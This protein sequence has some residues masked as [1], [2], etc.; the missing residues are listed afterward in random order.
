MQ[1]AYPGNLMSEKEFLDRL[2]KAGLPLTKTFK[3]FDPMKLV[4][5]PFKSQPKAKPGKAFLQGKV[6]ALFKDLRSQLVIYH[7]QPL[8]KLAHVPARI[9]ALTMIVGISDEL[10]SSL[11]TL[12][13]LLGGSKGSKDFQLSELVVEI[14]D[15][16]GKLLQFLLYV[17][18]WTN[19]KKLLG[20]VLSMAPGLTTNGMKLQSVTT[21]HYAEVLDPAHWSFDSCVHT[22]YYPQYIKE[23]RKK[24]LENTKAGK[25]SNEGVEPFILWME[26]KLLESGHTLKDVGVGIEYMTADERKDVAVEFVDGKACQWSNTE[27]GL[28][29]LP[30][31][32]HAGAYSIDQDGVIYFFYHRKGEA[33]H[34]TATAGGAVIC[35][36][37]FSLDSES[38]L[39]QIDDNTGHY[40]STPHMIISAL[41]ILEAHKALGPKTMA[42]FDPFCGKG[43][44]FKAP[45]QGLL[46]AA[47]NKFPDNFRK[48]CI[49]MAKDDVGPISEEKYKKFAAAAQ[50]VN[51]N[52]DYYKLSPDAGDEFLEG[53]NN[54]IYTK[55]LTRQ[56]SKAVYGKKAPYAKP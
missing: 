52:S 4:A 2:E 32:M 48:Q 30:M 36:G 49:S 13:S 17:Q 44:N 34:S 37:C 7:A 45:A 35:A 15:N 28:V 41:Q 8:G 51:W 55:G 12:G 11:V 31:A 53:V 6:P 40:A 19:P 9:G 1:F 43:W 23:T 14:M 42:S 25:P 27:Q 24:R 21:R 26:S 18:D 39:R 47:K 20:K 16:A 3:G 50:D 38:R 46:L 5:S 10:A 29:L 54:F 22:G 56:R 33:H